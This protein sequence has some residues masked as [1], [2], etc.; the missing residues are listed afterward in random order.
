MDVMAL[1]RGLLAPMATVSDD[2]H[3]ECGTF[4]IAA[5]TKTYT[6]SHGLGAVP[7]FCIVYPINIA[8]TSTIY[9]IAFEVLVGNIGQ[10]DWDITSKTD[11]YGGWHIMYSG[12]NYATNNAGPAMVNNA[13][14]GNGRAGTATSTTFVVGG[15]NNKG[16][17]G[18]LIA[19]TYGYILGRLNA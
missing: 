7:D 18:T 1:R 17:S 15:G 5:D 12:T 3:L 11:V 6:I 19:G 2:K 8:K 14:G 13:P 10:Q 4:T 16:A 9:A